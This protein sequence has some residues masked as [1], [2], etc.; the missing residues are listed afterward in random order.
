MVWAVGEAGSNA[1]GDP[2]DPSGS[3]F[4]VLEERLLVV[5]GLQRVLVRPFLTVGLCLALLVI[6][7]NIVFG[8]DYTPPLLTPGERTAEIVR[9]VQLEYV[10]EEPVPGLIAPELRVRVGETVAGL[11]LMGALR[12]KVGQAELWVRP[13]APGLVVRSLDDG[14]QLALP[15]QTSSVN[16][17]GLAFLSAGSEQAILLPAHGI[18]LRIVRVGRGTLAPAD[19]D[20]LVEVFRNDQEEPVDRFEVTKSSVVAVPTGDGNA[21]NLAFVPLPALAIHMRYSPGDWLLWVAFGVAFLGALGY[22]GRTGF[23]LAQIGPWPEHRSVMVV[24]SSLPSELAAIRRWHG[25]LTAD[26]GESER[27]Q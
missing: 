21:T 17:L 7:L 23:L 1:T 6:W 10:L 9:G 15:G 14:P 8:W 12:D 22:L 13:A 25:E 11:P 3:D 16:W 27:Q 4:V 5:R 18:G 20:L 24:Q 2:V 19:D 26:T